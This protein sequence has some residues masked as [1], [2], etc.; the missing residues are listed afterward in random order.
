M[1]DARWNFVEKPHSDLA[2]ERRVAWRR[3]RHVDPSNDSKVCSSITRVMRDHPPESLKTREL[4]LDQQ[5]QTTTPVPVAVTAWVHFGTI[6]LKVSA[7]AITRTEKAGGI[8]FTTPQGVEHKM[9]VW[10]SAVEKQ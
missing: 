8:R 9:W 7:E 5:P 3:Q 1:R 4:E 10:A 2:A 6:P